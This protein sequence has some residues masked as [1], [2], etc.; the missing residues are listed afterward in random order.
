[1]FGRSQNAFSAHDVASYWPAKKWANAVTSCIVNINGSRGLRRIARRRCSIATSG[2]PPRNALTVPLAYQ[3]VARFGFSESARSTSARAARRVVS[4]IS[5]ARLAVQ[6]HILRRTPPRQLATML[7][8]DALFDHFQ[9][10]SSNVLPQRVEGTRSARVVL[11]RLPEKFHAQIFCRGFFF[12]RNFSA[13]SMGDR[14]R[15]GP[16][17][18]CTAPPRLRQRFVLRSGHVQ[19]FQT[20]RAHPRAPP[21]ASPRASLA[22]TVRIRPLIEIIRESGRTSALSV[23]ITCFPTV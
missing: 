17:P 1:M 9:Q 13:P 18:C 20:L 14:G 12:L 22:E 2:S 21:L 4:A 10:I 11:P 23:R 15:G 16:A 3:A 7:V 6:P 8:L 5:C 19:N